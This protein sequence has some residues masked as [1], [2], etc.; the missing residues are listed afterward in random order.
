M[1]AGLGRVGPCTVEQRPGALDV[2]TT[3]Q[4][5]CEFSLTLRCVAVGARGAPHT[6]RLTNERLGLVE[7]AP[8]A[9]LHPD[10]LATLG[11]APG[12]MITVASRRGEVS[13]HARVDGLVVA[14]GG[15]TELF[16]V[17]PDIVCLAKALGG[18][19]PCGAVGG[20]D[21][22]M[23]AISDGV[24]PGRASPAA[25]IPSQIHRP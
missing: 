2:A 4:Q 12:D 21:E 15:A 9:S 24:R 16:G 22:V 8:V 7:S 10:D 3:R 1:L 14:A 25:R 13:L 18:G 19:V 5:S 6:D 20:T 23:S 17:R 11:V